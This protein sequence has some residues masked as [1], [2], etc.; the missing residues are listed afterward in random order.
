MTL[1]DITRFFAMGGYGGYVWTAY[2]LAL[3]GIAMEIVLA[4]RRHRQAAASIDEG[5]T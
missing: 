1:E 4:R 5:R 3:M 2:G